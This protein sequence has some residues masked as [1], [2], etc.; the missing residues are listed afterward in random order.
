MKRVEF[1]VPDRTEDV[2]RVRR[3]MEAASRERFVGSRPNPAFV[4][5]DELDKDAGLMREIEDLAR[6]LREAE[7]DARRRAMIETVL[8]EAVVE[9]AERQSERRDAL[10]TPPTPS[11]EERAAANKARFCEMTRGFVDGLAAARR[12]DR[13]NSR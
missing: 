13:E 11:P 10:F 3:A 8:N 4:E 9:L 5:P 2:A 12:L 1:P 6:Q 7:S